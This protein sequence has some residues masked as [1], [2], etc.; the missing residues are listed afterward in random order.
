MDARRINCGRRPQFSRPRL[1]GVYSSKGVQI[2]NG[3]IWSWETA[4]EKWSVITFDLVFW[5][6][7]IKL[8]ALPVN[9]P[10]PGR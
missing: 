9:A 5:R 10:R 1:S 8:R 7:T 4:A 3:T 2:G 6:I